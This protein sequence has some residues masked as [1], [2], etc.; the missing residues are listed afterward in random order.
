MKNSGRCNKCIVFFMI[1]G[2]A[3]WH[4]AQS[5]ATKQKP[6]HAGGITLNLKQYNTTVRTELIAD[7]N[8]TYANALVMVLADGIAVNGNS[9][10]VDKLKWQEYNAL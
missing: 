3:V 9:M 4:N 6:A 8:F 7:M 1:Y 5:W 2:Y 10:S